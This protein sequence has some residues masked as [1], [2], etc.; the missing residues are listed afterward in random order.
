LSEFKAVADD[1]VMD[2]SRYKQLAQTE[3]EGKKYYLIGV[4]PKGERAFMHMIVTLDGQKQC[5]VPFFNPRGE[6]MSF[7]P[8][9]P[10]SVAQQLILQIAQ[11]EIQEM[12]GVRVYQKRLLDL[13]KKNGN[14]IAM[15]PEE[16]WAISKL[17]VKLPSNIKIS[18]P[19]RVAE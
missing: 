16:F 6:F 14:Q 7:T 12:G 4:F 9:V 1:Y 19:P 5:N 18:S 11:R 17:G 8:D 10:Q 3:Y 2:P 13:A 15:T